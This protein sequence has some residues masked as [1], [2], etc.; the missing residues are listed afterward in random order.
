M[1][2]IYFIKVFS[3]HTKLP[4]EFD[5]YRLELQL[6]MNLVMVELVKISLKKV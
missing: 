1:I 6:F 3:Y 4:L 5:I 2:L